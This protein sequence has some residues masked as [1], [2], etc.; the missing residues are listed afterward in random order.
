[1]AERKMA[2][3]DRHQDYI[4]DDSDMNLHGTDAEVDKPHEREEEL[5]QTHR[6]ADRNTDRHQRGFNGHVL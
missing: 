5:G 3:N 4:A 2:P 1:M 6:H